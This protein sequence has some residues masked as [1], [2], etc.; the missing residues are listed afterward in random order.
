MVPVAFAPFGRKVIS[1]ELAQKLR[2][3]KADKDLKDITG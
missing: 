2:D 3:M 1:K